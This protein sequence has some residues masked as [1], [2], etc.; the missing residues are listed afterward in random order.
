MVSGSWLAP[1]V[2]KVD[3]KLS[4]ASLRSG[5]VAQD[6]RERGISERVW[7][8]LSEGFASSCVVTQSVV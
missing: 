6:R 3:K 4:E 5:V 2:G 8:A 7:K 1:V